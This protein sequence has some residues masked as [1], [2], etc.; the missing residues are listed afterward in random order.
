VS[1]Y[2]ADPDDRPSRAEAM[3]N[4]YDDP[5]DCQGEHNFSYFWRDTGEPAGRCYHCGLLPEQA[6]AFDEG[7]S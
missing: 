4:E 2:D 3:A 1:R 5:A 6:E 7:A